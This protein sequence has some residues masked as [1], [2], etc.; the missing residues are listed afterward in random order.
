MDNGH[1]VHPNFSDK[2]DPAHKPLMNHGPVIKINAN[3]RY[4]TTASSK[5]IYKT[6]A[7][8]VDVPVQEFVMRND[9]TCGSTIGPMTSAEL[10]VRT[11]D[12]GAPTLAMHS[13]REMTGNRDPHMLYKTIHHYLNR[14]KLPEIK[15]C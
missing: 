15:T 14:S 8:E 3:Q 6:I 13:I 2:S 11:I 1:A 9:I 5:A 12:V 10:G 4:A 7:A